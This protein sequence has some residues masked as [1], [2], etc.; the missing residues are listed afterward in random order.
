MA[1]EF[2][3]DFAIGA[4]YTTH[5]RTITETDIVTFVNLFGFHEPL[6]IDMEFVKNRSLFGDRIAPGSFT[7]AL[8]EGMTIQSGL[9]RGGMALLGV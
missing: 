2:F 7:F 9:V 4:E 1:V 8:S 5:A 6:F 3:E